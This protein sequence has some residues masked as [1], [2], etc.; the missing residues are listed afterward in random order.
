M[1]IGE[2]VASTPG[3]GPHDDVL[4]DPVLAARGAARARAGRARRAA[5]AAARAAEL[6]SCSRSRRAASPRR[7]A[8]R[9]R[10]RLLRLRAGAAHGGR[11]APLVLLLEMIWLKPPRL[12]RRGSYSGTDCMQ[13][14]P[15]RTKRNP[16]AGPVKRV[17]AYRFRRAAILPHADGQ[18]SQPHADDARALRVARAD[19]EWRVQARRAHV[20][21]AA[22][23][24]A[25]GFAHAAAP[26]ARLAR[27]RGTAARAPH[28]RLRRA[29]VHS[30]RH[31]ATRSSC[32]A[33][34]RA[35]RAASP[36]SREPAAATCARCAR[37]TSRSSRSCTAPTMSRSSATSRSTASSTRG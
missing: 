18:P 10:S 7:P 9:A 19:P 13:R 14:M 28:R 35:P 25:G 21:A 17:L 15:N 22:R 11:S 30:G 27:A 26:G 33:C 32:A 24:A 12:A 23:R 37:S 16:F 36:P 3:L 34:S 2:P 8:R 31:A 1:L 5:R 6:L 29:R 4:V 20:R